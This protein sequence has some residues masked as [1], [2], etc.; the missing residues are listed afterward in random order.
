M[1]FGDNPKAILTLKENT[2]ID[3]TIHPKCIFQKA[4][5]MIDAFHIFII[6]DSD[7]SNSF[8][9]L[10]NHENKLG[11]NQLNFIYICLYLLKF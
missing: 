6:L 5:S 11:L 4:N 10:C 8:Y 7:H 2:Q 3:V 1:T 9:D